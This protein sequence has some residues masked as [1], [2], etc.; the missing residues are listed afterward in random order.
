MIKMMDSDEIVKNNPFLKRMSEYFN[1]EFNEV[2]G[3]VKEE[4]TVKVPLKKLES[5]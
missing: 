4:N 3:L 1:D 2:M 5:V